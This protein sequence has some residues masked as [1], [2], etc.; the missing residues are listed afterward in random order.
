MPN[1]IGQAALGIGTGAASGLIGAGM[2]LLLEGHNDRRQL[3][4]QKKLQ[5]LQMQGNKS[6]VDYNMQ[7]QF[8]MWQKTGYSAQKKQMEEAGLNPALLYGISGGGGQTTGQATGAVSA[9]EA[10]KGG[11]EMTAGMGIMSNAQ[12][13]LMNAQ[14]E[15]IEADTKNKRAEKPVKDATVPNIEADTRGKN[16]DNELKAVQAS[17]ARQTIMDAMKTI[18]NAA[19][20]GT[21]EI[22]ALKLQNKLSEAQF[23]DKM[24]HL[25]Q[26]IAE[27]A[28]RKALMN[29]QQA[30]TQQ[31]TKN[32]I[33]EV[34]ESQQR[35][36]TMVGQL[37]IA[38]DDRSD[39]SGESNMRI[40][41][42][43]EDQDWDFIKGALPTFLLPIG[44]GFGGGGTPIRG[45]HNR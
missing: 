21:E 44:K 40:G 13:A 6:M 7:K 42:G 4:Q 27:I 41:Q 24:V 43:N 33:Q 38:W 35:I 16:L 3:A 45:F 15:N 22:N 31:D 30:N 14:K 36:K 18:E 1:D 34:L 10:V 19:A 20:K 12:L 39:R 2:G 9:G 32:K 8:E 28:V 26:Q 11:P 37:M 5:E 25:K 17:V 23:N 29:A